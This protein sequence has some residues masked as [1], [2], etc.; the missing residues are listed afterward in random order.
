[1][2]I[3]KQMNKFYTIVE[4]AAD[5]KPNTRVIKK[6]D[7]LRRIAGRIKAT[8]STTLHPTFMAKLLRVGE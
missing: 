7:E 8:N 2:P 1:M 5:Q 6:L 3:M 4:R